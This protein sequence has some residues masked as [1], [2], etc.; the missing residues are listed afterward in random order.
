MNTLVYILI[1]GLLLVLGVVVGYFARQ[2]MANQ[3]LR[4]SQN[5]AKRLLNEAAEKHEKLLS[6]AREEAIKVRAAAES[7]SRQR[8]ADLHLLNNLSFE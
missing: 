8:R 1:S 6:E 5:E 7:D 3:Q 2:L 4:G